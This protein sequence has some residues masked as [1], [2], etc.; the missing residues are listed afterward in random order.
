MNLSSDL[1][2]LNGQSEPNR[3]DDANGRSILTADIGVSA[4]KDRSHC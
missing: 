3:R 2:P 4:E 1:H